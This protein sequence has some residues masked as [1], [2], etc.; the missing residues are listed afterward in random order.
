MIGLVAFL[1]YAAPMTHVWVHPLLQRAYYI[2]ILLA[3]LW[4]GWRGGLAAAALAGASY[5]PHIISA[6]KYEPEYT[7]AQYIEVGMFLAIATL[8]GILADHERAQRRKAEES[9]RNLT[10]VNAQLQASFDQLRRADR[11]SALG[12][13]SAGLAHE[14]RNP[15]G[16]IEGAVQILS[17]RE[18]PDETRT[19]F[20]DMAFREV[21]RLKGL[22]S[23]FL[24]FARPQQPRVVTSDIE[25][26]LESVA[27]LASETARM[28]KVDITV[29][30][31]QNLPAA[32]MDPEQIRQVL[33][34]LVINAVQAMSA[35][36][37][38]R[39]RA[40]RHGDEVQIEVQDEGTGIPDDNLERIFDPFFTTRA[41]GTGLGLSIA[42]QIV[43]K[44]RG[45]IAAR[46]NAERGMTF[47][48]TLPICDE[49][50]A[51]V[52]VES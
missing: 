30:T 33:L 20:A 47:T 12:E 27:R 1:H 31:P 48:V 10:A 43:N 17:R 41:S 49:R 38:I 37:T 39:L 19:E 22:L 25:S 15:L 13:L 24:E 44:H 34:N 2:P 26:L 5:I 23:H 35:G 14:I 32:S 51:E 45:H 11:L 28:A 29:E 40:L 3:A 52:Q 16:S 6:W 7:A 50:T 36:G 21:S 46:R 18:L 4:F 42:Y 8:T 9:A